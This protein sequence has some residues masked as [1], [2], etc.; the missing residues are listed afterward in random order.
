MSPVRIG[1]MAFVA[2][3]QWPWLCGSAQGARDGGRLRTDSIAGLI[4]AWDSPPFEWCPAPVT[5][6]TTPEVYALGSAG[7]AVGSRQT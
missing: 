4:F 1:G 3:E 2:N 6:S 7:V 5:I